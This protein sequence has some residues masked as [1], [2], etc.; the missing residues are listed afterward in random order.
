MLNNNFDDHRYSRQ[1]LFSGIGEEGQAQLEK[2]TV[3]IVGCGALGSSHANMLARAGVK[4][5]RIIDRDFVELSNLQRQTLFKEKHARDHTPK[6]IAIQEELRDINAEVEVEPKVYDFNASNCKALLSG[7]DLV[8][9]GTDNFETRF[10]LNE[11]CVKHELPWIYGACVA[12]YGMSFNII[13]GETACLQCL[14]RAIPTSNMGMTCETAGIIGPIVHLVSSFQVNEA[15]KFLC[16]KRDLMRRTLLAIDMW[17]NQ[18]QELRIP[19]DKVSV[20]CPVCA[21][22]KYDFLEANTGSHVTSLCGRDAIQITPVE[23]ATLNLEALAE[24]LSEIGHTEL[25]PYLLRLTLGDEIITIF[26]DGRAMIKGTKDEARA[27]SL[28]AKY[29]GG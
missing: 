15:L 27:R 16:G 18:I 10:L 1:I 9:D 11:Y 24:T 20:D 7:V 4:R 23:T 14:F 3:A 19:E 21:M 26:N 29:V 5:L 8:V 22:S 13:P 6:A 2:H 17:R 12:A 25:N 28:Y